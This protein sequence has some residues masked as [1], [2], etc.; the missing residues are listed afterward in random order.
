[1]R[2]D[3]YCFV[4]F[5]LTT[6]KSMARPIWSRLNLTLQCVTYKTDRYLFL[7]PSK[8]SSLRARA[9]RPS[10]AGALNKRRYHTKT[11]QFNCCPENV[12]FEK[13]HFRDQNIDVR[14]F[15]LITKS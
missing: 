13:T 10:K 6:N 9:G 11:S 2:T 14:I 15:L 3:E 7:R 4:F 5:S 12:Q 8:L 1:M